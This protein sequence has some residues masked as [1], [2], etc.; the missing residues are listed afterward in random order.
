MRREVV[1]QELK[2]KNDN[3]NSVVTQKFEVISKE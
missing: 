1:A 3:D 2:T